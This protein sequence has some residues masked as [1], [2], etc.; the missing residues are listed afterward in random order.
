MNL[1]PVRLGPRRL[2][3]AS[4]ITVTDYYGVVYTRHWWW[5]IIHNTVALLG[6]WWIII[7]GTDQVMNNYAPGIMGK[8]TTKMPPCTGMYA[9]CMHICIYVFSGQ[10]GPESQHATYHQC[11]YSWCHGSWHAWWTLHRDGLNASGHMWH[12][13]MP[14]SYLSGFRQYTYIG[15]HAMGH[16]VVSH[17]AIL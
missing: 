6:R 3:T 8:D 17:H 11:R 7:Q 13:T 14:R 15:L 12:C 16:Y 5:T 2:V 9:A 10:K 1:D 4:A